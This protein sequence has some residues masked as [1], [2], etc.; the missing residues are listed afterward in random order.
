MWAGAEQRPRRPFYLVSVEQ[1]VKPASRGAICGDT[2]GQAV[3]GH[4]C[5]RRAL[6]RIARPRA[7]PP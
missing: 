5:E 1:R 6:E 7:A 4:N 3:V 2:A